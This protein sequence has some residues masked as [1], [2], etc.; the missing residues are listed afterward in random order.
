[1]HSFLARLSIGVRLQMATAFALFALMAL[2]VSV[3]ITETRR[4][5]ESRVSLLQSV[6]ETAA[7]IAAAYHREELAGHLTRESAQALAAAAIKAMR[8]QGAEY[9]WI[10]DMQPKMVMH[11]VKPEL[12]GQ[13]L[14]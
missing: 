14:A 5:R 7:G 1:M 9:V 13:D 10:N 6:D 11:P 3:Q 4:M 12:D 8:Y 2:L